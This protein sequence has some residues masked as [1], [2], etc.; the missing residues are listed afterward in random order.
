L[1]T[2]IELTELQEDHE[3]IED[4]NENAV[5][6]YAAMIENCIEEIAGRS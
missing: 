5:E 1:K 6:R 3:E 2:Q 4:Y